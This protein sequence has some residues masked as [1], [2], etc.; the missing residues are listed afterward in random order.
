M[1]A[2]ARLKLRDLAIVVDE[3]HSLP[4]YAVDVFSDEISNISV[5]RGISEVNKYGV[6]GGSFLPSLRK[7]LMILGRGAKSIHGVGEE[8]VI[9]GERLLKPLIRDVGCRSL[10]D[11]TK[12]LSK[13][14]EEGEKVR[15]IRLERGERPVSYLY[16]CSSFILSWIQLSGKEYV[17]YCRFDEDGGGREKYIIG[18]K[19][20]DPSLSTKPLSRVKSAVLMS[21]TLWNVDYYVEVLGI[22]KRRIE[23]L[24]LPNPFPP[25]NQLILVDKGVSTRFERRGPVEWSKLANHL[26]TI[27]KKVNGRIAVYFPSYDVMWE[28]LRNLNLDEVKIL[29]E[30]SKTKISDAKSFLLKNRK[31][32]ISG[33][34]RGKLSEGVDIT[35][36]GRSMLSCVIIAGLPYPKKTEVQEAVLKYFNDKFGEKGFEYAM[37][38]PCVNAV[39]QSAGRLIRSERDRE[40][41]VL[42]DSR[43]VGRFKNYLPED[44]RNRLEPHFKIEK[45]V[46][47]AKRFMGV[48]VN[49]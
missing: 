1:F 39:A 18:M 20:L 11:L 5:E 19:C 10:E 31:C 36:K 47:K 21:G 37:I 48:E 33:V 34:A 23:S 46:E 35:F 3:A 41:I 14:A 12:L 15:I 13:L 7:T 2:S 8:Y 28:I 16:R 42:M 45:L 26:S 27:L 49:S 30:E 4:R 38:M 24:I 6:K 29:I 44:W 32:V 9:G 22:D 40:I 17:K 25:E 43:V